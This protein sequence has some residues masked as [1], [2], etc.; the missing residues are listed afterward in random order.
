[1]HIVF[2]RC[3]HGTG[4]IMHICFFIIIHFFFL[5]YYRAYQTIQRH[6]LVH[7]V[8]INLVLGER[9]LYPLEAYHC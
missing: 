4:Q 5:R 6:P 3:A 9:H 7:L 8:N 1:M 2:W